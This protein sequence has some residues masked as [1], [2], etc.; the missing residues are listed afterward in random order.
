ME[1][2]HKIISARWVVPVNE[3]RDIL[4]NHSVVIK[5]DKIVEILKTEEALTKYQP[6]E[7]IALPGHALIPGFVNSHGH[8]AMTLFRGMADDLELMT[9]L[10]DHIWPAEGKWVSPEFVADGTRF[11]IGEM[12]R[13]GT[14]CFSDNYFYGEEVAQEILKSGIRG[15]IC[16]T[17]IDFPTPGAETPDEGIQN[18]MDLWEKYKD[19]D[20]V[21]PIFGPHAPYTVSDEPF[22]KI[23]KL[24]KENNILIQMHVHET[25]TEVDGSIEQ[26]GKR[27]IKRLHDLGLLGPHMQCVHMTALNEEDIEIIAETGSHVMHCPESNL[28]LASGFC[29]VHKLQEK[30]INV[31]LGTDGAASNND[32]DMLG[33]M[34]TAAQLAKAVAQNAEALPAYEALALATINGAK[35]MAKEDKF[36]S[37]EAGKFADV[38]AV[39]L[40]DLESQPIFDPVSHIVYA[41]TRNQV[42]DVW[43]GGKQLLANRE[44]TTL[45]I[46]ELIATAIEWK[47]KIVKGREQTAEK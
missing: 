22:K 2:V 44:L 21:M 15:Q 17:V 7:K 10:N 14:T 23:I 18:A 36:G 37:L 26:Y 35:S 38:V 30:G 5:E 3:S 1:S 33:E 13:S 29:P 11:A 41:T 28:K 34:R 24:A 39:D 31:T 47:E 42:T 16:S 46:S 43:V 9:W 27:P 45:P 4:E 32:L 25:Q 12:I 40:S 20:Y 6:D 8:A 19:N